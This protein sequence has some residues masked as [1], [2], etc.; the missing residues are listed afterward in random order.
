[1]SSS[2]SIISLLAILDDFG[3]QPPPVIL[4]SLLNSANSFLAMLWR[5]F[6]LFLPP[7]LFTW[8]FWPHLL[9][10]LFLPIAFV[11][12]CWS[13]HSLIWIGLSHDFFWHYWWWLQSHKLK[14]CAVFFF[15]SFGF[16]FQV[17][18]PFP[19]FFPLQFFFRA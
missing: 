1:M 17:H 14:N 19:P 12:I 18:S 3:G 10:G 2:T 8:L 7:W 9:L 4:F 16:H 5:F 11:S 15:L 6:H 13:Q